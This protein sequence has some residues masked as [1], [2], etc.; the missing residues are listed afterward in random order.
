MVHDSIGD[1]NGVGGGNVDGD[2][3]ATWGFCVIEKN[4]GEPHVRKQQLRMQCHSVT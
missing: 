1:S 2:G 4:P 3:H